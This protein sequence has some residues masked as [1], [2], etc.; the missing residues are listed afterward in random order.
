[1]RKYIVDYQADMV[2]PGVYSISF[3]SHWQDPF[4]GRNG[5]DHVVLK[6]QQK[7]SMQKIRNWIAKWLSE[8]ITPKG[9]CYMV[10]V[11]GMSRLDI[12]LT[13]QSGCDIME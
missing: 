13:I 10:N 12:G 8:D 11:T 5:H 3:K 9:R 6:I 4:S 7:T 1:M 2:P